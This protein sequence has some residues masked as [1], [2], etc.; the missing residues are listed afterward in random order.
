MR[1]RVFLFAYGLLLSTVMFSA[2][3]LQGQL[4]DG[5]ID[6]GEY[7]TTLKGSEG[8]FTLA[9]TIAG[10]KIYFAMA[11][12][13]NG[14]VAVG[15]DPIVV[16]DNA[17]LLFGWVDGQGRPS[18]VDA[19]S[20]GAYGPFPPDTKLGGTDDILQYAGTEQE[21]VTTLEFSRLLNTGDQYDSTISPRGGNKIIWMYG[22]VDDY[23][24]RFTD[25]GYTWLRSDKGRAA[26]LSLW[27]LLR[28]VLIAFSIV[29]LY[30]GFFVPV[31]RAEREEKREAYRYLGLGGVVLGVGGTVLTVLLA[32]RE[33]SF[34]PRALQL[35]FSMASAAALLALGGM[36]LFRFRPGPGTTKSPFI[37]WSLGLSFF[38]LVL[39]L[40]TGLVSHY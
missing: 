40:A 15:L 3:Q 30:F 6:E 39:T 24:T 38:F 1:G 26:G 12:Q 22:A 5:V 32:A 36:L 16:A 14:W 2:A 9:W 28:F 7:E 10:D 20:L 23:N 29:L 4:I 35:G 37:R 34:I 19:Y 13:T 27:T 21:G 18:M 31:S 11:A 8:R 25:M 33:T 17:D